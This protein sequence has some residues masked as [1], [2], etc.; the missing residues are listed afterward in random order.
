MEPLWILLGALVAV[1]VLAG[2]WI[3]FTYNR[4]ITLRERFKNAYSQIDVQLKRRHDLI[5]N[6]VETVKGYMTHERQTLDAVIQARNQAAAAGRQAA[7][8]PENPSAIR[9]IV[10]AESMLVAALGQFM[11]LR[12]AYPQ[13]KADQQAARL[14]EELASAENRIAFARQHY[15]DAVMSYN[16]YRQSFPPMLVAGPAGFGEAVLFEISDPREREAQQ[17]SF[18]RAPAVPG[19]ARA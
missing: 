7:E 16:A 8:H 5:P 11:M 12:E 15:N 2:L 9:G 4:L 6:L 3:A 1:F 10:G 19:P 18:D 17:V 13:L 14:M